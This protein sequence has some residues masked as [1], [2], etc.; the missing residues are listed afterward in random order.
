[1]A[2]SLVPKPWIQKVTFRIA[3]DPSVAMIA[4]QNNEIDVLRPSGDQ[5]AV[6]TLEAGALGTTVRAIP[7]SAGAT[8]TPPC[9]RNM[10]WVPSG[11]KRGLNPLGATCTGSPPSTGTM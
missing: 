7:P 4:Y 1:M 11:E 10:I 8:D 3:P 9:A 2:A 5:L 6:L